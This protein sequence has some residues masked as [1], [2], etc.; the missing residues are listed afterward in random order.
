M[1]LRLAF[2]RSSLSE[3]KN[4]RLRTAVSMPSPCTFFWKRLRSCSCDS[5]S[6]NLTVAI[7]PI[8]PPSVEAHLD[9]RPLLEPSCPLD[10]KRTLHAPEA[11]ARARGQ[12]CGTRPS[13]VDSDPCVREDSNKWLYIYADY[14]D[15]PH[16]CQ[17]D[18]CC[19]ERYLPTP[20]DQEKSSVIESPAGELEG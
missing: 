20:V 16:M 15:A 14:R 12:R 19:M 2:R 9:D 5:P 7:L 6:C 11:I 1:A 13:G 17:G 18:A 8:S 4:R 3:T 10:R